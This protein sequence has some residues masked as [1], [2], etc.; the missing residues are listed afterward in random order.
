MLQAHQ[1]EQQIPATELVERSGLSLEWW[2]DA[3]DARLEPSDAAQIDAAGQALGLAPGQ[4]QLIREAEE[5]VVPIVCPLWCTFDDYAGD[6]AVCHM[7][8]NHLVNG[9]LVGATVATS[10]DGTMDDDASIRVDGKG[11][12]PDEL[13]KLYP[14]VQL[15]VAQLPAWTGGQSQSA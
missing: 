14:A 7:S 13:L 1:V 10:M 3:C 2:S 11:Y 8:E 4:G 9:V 5:R 12:S 6:G 15:A